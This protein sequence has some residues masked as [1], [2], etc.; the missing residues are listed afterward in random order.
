VKIAS[1]VVRVNYKI[2]LLNVHALEISLHLCVTRV[3]SAGILFL[4]L[5]VV[6]Y[7]IT[8]QVR[9]KDTALSH[10]LCLT[11]YRHI[12]SIRSLAVNQHSCERECD[13][14]VVVASNC[15]SKSTE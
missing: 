2:R 11:A 1:L 3:N 5:T 7:C 13:C 4:G 8:A 10:I 9:E 12:D 6:F 14:S 15:F